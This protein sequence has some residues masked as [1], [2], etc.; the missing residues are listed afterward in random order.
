MAQ[1][2]SPEVVTFDEFPVTG[3]LPKDSTQA[4]S[5]RAETQC[6]GR[7]ARIAVFDTGVD[8]GCAGLQVTTEGKRKVI[9]AVDCSGAGDTA[10][11]DAAVAE[12]GTLTLKS[13]RKVQ[14]PETWEATEFKTGLKHAADFFPGPLMK[15]IKDV[16]A[17]EFKSQREQ[18]RAEL[19]RQKS[20]ENEKEQKT[21][22]DEFDALAQEDFGP[23]YDVIAWKKNDEWYATLLEYG[24]DVAEAL[25]P[26]RNFRVAQESAQLCAQS[27]LHVALNTYDDGNVV[28]V[29]APNGSHG[30]H[31]AGIASAHFP[32]AADG[33]LDGVA[34]GA[35]VVSCVIGDCRVGTMETVQALSRAMRV[36]V[37]MQV[38]VINLSYGE[39]MAIHSS[40]FLR[41]QVRQLSQQHGVLFVSSAGNSGPLLSTIGAPAATCPEMMSIGAFVTPAMLAAE[42]NLLKHESFE[43]RNMF[44]WSSRGPN[45]GGGLGVSVCAPGAAI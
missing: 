33:H 8:L 24:R 21:L 26:M 32:D 16:R 41:D 27:Q 5:F 31:V 35:Q 20:D 38:D 6:D 30:T 4:S 40:G 42:Y 29:V 11:T 14:V 1:S 15:R 18:L 2:V 22:I 9:E 10:M 39:S 7:R 37:E 28:S 23:V 13:G 34:P 43:E 19:L 45:D 44:T 25:P 36:A 12:D 3:L 17:D